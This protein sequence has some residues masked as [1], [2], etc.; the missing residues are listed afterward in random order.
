MADIEVKELSNDELSAILYGGSETPAPVEK[1]KEVPVPIEKVDEIKKEKP[2]KAGDTEFD[3]TDLE[4]LADEKVEEGKEEKIILPTEK[5][6][7]V[8][9][10]LPNKGRKPT[11][12]VSAVNELIEEELLFPFEDGVPKTIEEAKELIRLNLSQKEK[13]SEDKFW[14]NKVSKYSPQ[15]QAIIEYAE[16]GGTDVAPLLSA[17]SEIERSGDF[18]IEKEKDQE[19]VIKEYL[20]IN[21][22][23]DA[24]I[25]EE[26]E[27]AKDLGKLKTKAEKFLPKLNQM[28]EQRIQVIMEEQEQSK[29]RAEET[30]KE[31]LKN[32]KVNLDKPKVGEVKLERNDRAS[33]WDALTNIKYTSWNGQPTNGFFKKLEELQTAKDGNYEHFLEIVHLATNREAFIEKIREEIG[34]KQAAESA[35]KLK[36]E[37]TRKA[38]SESSIDE[39]TPAKNTIRRTFKNPWG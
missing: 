37:Q 30:R 2:A 22:W 28:N 10:P 14:E 39:E 35:R 13:G 32:L 33:L 23:D 4:K 31:Y 16:K 12:L 26:I 24:D 18:D 3:W 25:K 9:T 6:I 8:E 34:T 20:K 1:E 36:I 19:D 7:K 5:D 15:I 17:I 27:T 29:A 21:G 38:T 11:D